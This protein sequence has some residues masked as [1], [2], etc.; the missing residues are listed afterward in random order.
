MQK[1]QNFSYQLVWKLILKKKEWKNINIFQAQTICIR[2][3]LKPSLLFNRIPPI[4]C[5][6]LR[7]SRASLPYV[8]FV[9]YVPSCVMGPCALCA[10]ALYLRYL[11][12]LPYIAYVICV[13]YLTFLLRFLAVSFT[14]NKNTLGL[15][16]KSAKRNKNEDARWKL[17]VFPS[18]NNNY[19]FTY[20]VFLK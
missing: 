2:V 17:N 7:A 3:I 9:H 19:V 13:P 5:A 12:Y 14:L 10:L 1:F 6:K 18:K 16:V 4:E 15:L 11:F 8:S 20:F